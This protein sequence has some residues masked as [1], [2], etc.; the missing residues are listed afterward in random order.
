MRRKVAIFRSKCAYQD[1]IA[2]PPPPRSELNWE[3]SRSIEILH[4]NWPAIMIHD[5]PGK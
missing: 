4:I 5:F 3:I 1:D 2:Y